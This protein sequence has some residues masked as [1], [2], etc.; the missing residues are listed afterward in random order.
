MAQIYGSTDLEAERRLE[1]S[2]SDVVDEIDKKNGRRAIVA[3][4]ALAF[5]TG[6]LV[7]ASINAGGATN[8]AAS[9]NAGAT[10]HP[11]VGTLV[12]AST[13]AGD[14]TKLAASTNA[15]A[16]AHP[17]VG[18]KEWKYDVAGAPYLDK[19]LYG[20]SSG[21]LSAAGLAVWLDWPKPHQLSE[22]EN[23]HF[24]APSE[25][26]MTATLKSIGTE[27]MTRVT[28]WAFSGSLGDLNGF[29]AVDSPAGVE[30]PVPDPYSWPWH[31]PIVN[32][33]SGALPASAKFTAPK[34]NY[35]TYAEKSVTVTAFVGD[36]WYQSSTYKA[37]IC[38]EKC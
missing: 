31:G 16:T 32:K 15:G 23:Y 6:A 30:Y 36:K 10:A 19:E 7:H 22:K 26:V 25:Q 1:R 27:P 33:Q 24:Q 4:A 9:T 12:R 38:T 20:L 17:A 21:P 29:A 14:A 28:A 5:A 8:L 3:L 2:C 18:T 35:G 37:S 13:N 34:Y 11:A